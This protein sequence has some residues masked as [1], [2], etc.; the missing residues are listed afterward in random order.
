MKTV[1]ILVSVLLVCYS[2]WWRNNTSKKDKKIESNRFVIYLIEGRYINNL[3]YDYDEKWSEFLENAELKNIFISDE[4]IKCYNW[5]NQLIT[6]TK[7]ASKR[8]QKKLTTDRFSLINK[9]FIVVLDGK[10]EYAGSIIEI[11][12][13]RAINYPV[14]YI[15]DNEDAITINI[16][17]SHILNTDY[18]IS[19]EDLINKEEIKIFFNQIKKLT[20]NQP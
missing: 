2:F 9:T 1:I 19:E 20:D 11:F 3:P 16:R 4:D 15:S 7:G 6:L 14:M 10:R 12:S 13:A 8:I 5:N 18:Q 17:H